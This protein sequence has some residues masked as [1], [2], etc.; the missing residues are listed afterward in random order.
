MGIMMLRKVARKFLAPVIFVLLLALTIGLFYIGAPTAGKDNDLLYKGPAA[1]VFGIKVKDDE[2]NKLLVNLTQQASQSGMPYTQSQLRD[3][4][5]TKA[6]QEIALQQEIKKVHGQIKVSGSDV[7]KFIKKYFK[8][9]EEL[10]SFLE[11]QGLTKRD[12]QKVLAKDLE[13]QKFHQLNAEKLG[14]KVSKAEILKGIEQ[15]TVSHIL[16]SSEK[17]VRTGAAALKLANEVYQKAAAGGDFAQLAKEF[18]DDPGS[19]EK[20]GQYGPMSVGEFEKSMVKEFVAASLSLKKGEISKPVPTQYGYH[21][22][23]LDARQI[24]TGKEY[25]EKYSEAKKELL[26]QKIQGGDPKYSA[27]MKKIYTK[28]ET[29]MEILDPGLRAFRLKQEGKDKEA[30]LAYEKALTRSYYKNKWDFYLEASEVY[31]RLKQPKQALK[32]LQKVPAEFHEEVEY[33]IALALTYKTDNK[34]SKGIDSL[35]KFSAAHPEDE[36]L[37]ERLKEAFTE[38]KVPEMVAK[39]DSYIAEIA[40]KAKEE[41]A[42]RELNQVQKQDSNSNFQTSPTPAT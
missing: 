20:G 34:L 35:A 21:I 3:I 39:E 5:L 40:R 32:V 19:K 6:I 29:E 26:Y 22:I 23:K 28:A 30:A 8:T 10:Q 37:H 18:S 12:L 13:S 25:K 33:Q 17:S 14:I 9:D 31:L 16:I 38:W 1:K 27:W 2:F 24:P 42:K 7:N 41:Q 36:A 4:A 15:I 11:Q